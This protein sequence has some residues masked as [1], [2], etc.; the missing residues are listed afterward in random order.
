VC[1][2][3]EL[4]L[5]DSPSM[6]ATEAQ[7]RYELMNRV[8][9]STLSLLQSDVLDLIVMLCIQML[10]R[11]RRLPPVPPKLKLADGKFGIEYHGPLARAQRTDEVAAIERLASF[12]AALAKLEFQDARDVFDPVSAVRE[13]AAR[14][15]CPAGVLISED[16]VRAKIAQREAAATQLAKAQVA[17]AQ[18][19]AL[20]Q[21]GMG[22]QAMQEAGAPVPA[23]PPPVVNPPFPG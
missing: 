5:K 14:L 12:V 4:T 8:L 1:H 11:E 17:K 3:D 18:G 6:T 22:A 19:E 13:V 23:Q 7:I 15:G 10:A 2:E 21:A 9:G 16:K 20:E